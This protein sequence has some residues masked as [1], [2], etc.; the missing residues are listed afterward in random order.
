MT[1]SLVAIAVAVTLTPQSAALRIKPHA[2]SMQPGEVVLLT[3]TSA[4]PI[5]SLRARAFGRDLA[6]F[7]DDPRSWQVLVGIDLDVTPGKHPVTFRWTQPGE[8]STQTASYDFAVVAKSFRTRT[9]TVDN[10]FVNPPES[11]A[12]QIAADARALNEAWA[13]S[14]SRQWTSAF[15]AP[16]PQEANSAFGT[17]SVFNG[18][19]R[20]PHSGADFA[21]PAGTPVQAPSDGRVLI[22]RDMYYTGGTVVVDHG[23]G[24]ISLFAHLS[25]IDV[26]ENTRVEVGDVLGKVGATGR[27]TGPHL[28]WAMRI[29]GARVDPLALLSVLGKPPASKS[30]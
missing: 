10:A 30:H 13:T 19:P 2:R 9:L 3:V 17:R 21:S 4:A 14:S 28:H 20:S 27:V 26:K 25:A 11:A 6:P 24:V 22:A 5:D 8:R 15:L 23:L 18:Q 29:N 7:Q 16:V 12:A 1:K